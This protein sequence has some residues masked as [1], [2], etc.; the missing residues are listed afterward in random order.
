MRTFYICCNIVLIIKVF[1][2]SGT[3]R[4]ESSENSQI[5]QNKGATLFIHFIPSPA[6]PSSGK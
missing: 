4:T 1:R 3:L 2:I 5:P 6:H